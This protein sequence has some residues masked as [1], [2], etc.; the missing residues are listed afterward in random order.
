[1]FIRI[2]A[3]LVIPSVPLAVESLSLLIS[4][5]TVPYTKL[6]CLYS[7][8]VNYQ[9]LVANPHNCGEAYTVKVSVLS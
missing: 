5:Y 3:D 7:E 8:E 2:G 1:M 9:G 4:L 6:H